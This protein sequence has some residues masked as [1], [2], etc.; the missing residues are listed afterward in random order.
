MRYVLFEAIDGVRLV[1]IERVV[2]VRLANET[3][4]GASTV[5]LYLTSGQV[6]RVLETMEGVHGLLN[7]HARAGVGPLVG[8]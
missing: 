1:N 4:E 3:S 7:A 5:A 2:E 8:K 6:V